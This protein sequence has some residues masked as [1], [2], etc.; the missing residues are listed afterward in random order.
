MQIKR[1]TFNP[2]QENTWLAEAGNGLV[3][4]VDPGCG[5]GREMDALLSEVA[6]TA[7]GT[8]DAILLTHGHADHLL[9]AAA[10]QK[11]FGC[12]VLMHP[13]DRAT[14][15]SCRDFINLPGFDT[16]NLAFPKTTE[17]S[18][19]TLTLTAKNNCTSESGTNSGD[20][21][22][23]SV[24]QNPLAATGADAAVRQ[25]PPAVSGADAAAG[26]NP[27][28]TTSVELQVEVIE[29]P[30]HTP[31]G[32][33][34]LLRNSG[35]LFSGD[36]LFAGTIGRTD[37]PGGEYDLLI[38]SVMDSLMGLDADIEILP[39]HGTTSTIG[40]ERTHNPFLEPWGEPEEPFD[41][42]ATP[43]TLHA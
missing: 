24:G 16:A 43:I 10:L 2:F 34:F 23:A 39:G 5:E 1:F 25:N 27:P 28:A 33:C 8:L 14:I 17:I 19:G 6:K 32:V 18:S 30:G 29:T 12:P 37:L 38:K 13:A 41:P 4:V 9:G 20:G 42:D 40:W 22:D 11:R 36:T 15:L 21:T 31:G 26:Q 7:R 3:F 35:V